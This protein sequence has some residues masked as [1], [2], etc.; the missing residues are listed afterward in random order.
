MAC[1]DNIYTDIDGLLDTRSS[2][3]I[4]FWIL[5]VMMISTVSANL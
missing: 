2:T 5:K 4:S 3:Q 1:V